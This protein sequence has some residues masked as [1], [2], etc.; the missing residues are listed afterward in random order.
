[1]LSF[2]IRSLESQAVQV[3]GALS[4]DDPVWQEGDPIPAGPVRVHGRLSSAGGAGR[5]YF[6]GSLEGKLDA[7]CRR[8]L[9]AVPVSVEEQ[10]IHLIFVES[11]DDEAADDP[12]VYLLDPRARDL[13]LRPAIREHWLLSVPGYAECRPDCKGLCPTCGIDLNTGSCD[14]T[15]AAAESRWDALRAIRSDAE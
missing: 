14:C 6:S 4:A 10:N 7:E 12:D 2:D 1:M 9:T 8:C 15:P 5:F 3:E 11:G 13:D